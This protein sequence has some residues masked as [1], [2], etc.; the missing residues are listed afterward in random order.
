MPTLDTDEEIPLTDANTSVVVRVGDTVRRTPGFWTAS[1]HSLLRH[2]EAVGFEGA[3]RVLGF[4]ARSREILTF[5][6]GETIPPSLDGYRSDEMLGAV[7]ALLRRCHDATSDF[8]PSAAAAWRDGVGAPGVTEVMCH[9]DIAPWNTVVRDGQPVA[10]IDWDFAAPGR[11]IWDVAY[12]LWRFAPLYPNQTYGSLPERARRMRLFCDAYGLE[13]RR[14]LTAV[15]EWRQAVHYSTL[16]AWADAG[17]PVFER[18]WREGHGEAM[19]R[20]LSWM[21]SH[22]AE[23]EQLLTR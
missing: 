7:A 12:A 5:I 22:R 16:A 21:R 6:P 1:V 17:V 10:F 20:D 19:L 8:R 2:L 18:L 15:I 13:D 14:G 9:N 3:P 11:R 23:L 4:D